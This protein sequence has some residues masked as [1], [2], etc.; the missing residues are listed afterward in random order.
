MPKTGTETRRR[1]APGGAASLQPPV[2]CP[3]KVEVLEDTPYTLV[4]RVEG[5][6]ILGHRREQCLWAV[7]SKPEKSYAIRIDGIE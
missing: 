7:V 5:G 6:V 1:A 2:A 3:R 4:G